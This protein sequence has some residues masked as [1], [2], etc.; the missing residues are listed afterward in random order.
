MLEDL[1][2]AIPFYLA[3][4]LSLVAPVLLLISFISPEISMKNHPP[5]V[6]VEPSLFF[7]KF[8]AGKH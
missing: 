1:A 8:F 7:F 6:V 5:L 3:P 4:V 2:N